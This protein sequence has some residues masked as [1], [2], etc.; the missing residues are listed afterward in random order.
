MKEIQLQTWTNALPGKMDCRWFE[1]EHIGL[2]PTLF[3]HI[4]IPLKPFNSGLEYV[5][6]PENTEIHIDWIELGIPETEN[7]ENFILEKEGVINYEASIYIGSAH[8][9]I[10]INK[11]QVTA[12]NQH[13]YKVEGNIT[14]DFEFEGVAKK[15]DFEF[16]TA[17]EYINDT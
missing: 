14:V 9:P 2:K 4:V 16:Q 17:L 8:N 3:H 7:P 13:N 5:E 11:L 15:E 1:N 10:A 12:S 6:Q